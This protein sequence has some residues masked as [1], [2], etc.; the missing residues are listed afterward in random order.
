[1]CCW[2]LQVCQDSVAEAR[3]DAD[4]LSSRHTQLRRRC[5]QLYNGYRGLRYKLEDEWPQGTGA[6]GPRWGLGLLSAADL[7]NMAQGMAACLASTLLA[8]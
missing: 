7:Q 5:R 1:M 3:R 2:H 8:G 4:S 6:A